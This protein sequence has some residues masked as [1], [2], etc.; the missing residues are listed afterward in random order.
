MADRS[1]TLQTW[2]FQC[3]CV[4]FISCSNGSTGIDWYIDKRS[5]PNYDPMSSSYKTAFCPNLKCNHTAAVGTLRQAGQVI[6][7]SFQILMLHTENVII[8]SLCTKFILN[9]T[10]K[11]SQLTR[12]KSQLT[13]HMDSNIPE[14]KHLILS[15]QTNSKCV[16]FRL[17]AS[18]P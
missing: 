5:K 3:C 1:W 2:C 10:W 15:I 13:A 6:Q 12:K 8:S 7:S 16:I 9:Q 18:V 17:H 14:K 4:E 11:L